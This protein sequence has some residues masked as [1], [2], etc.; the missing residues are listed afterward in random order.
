MYNKPGWAILR[1]LIEGG[2]Q[3]RITCSEPQKKKKLLGVDLFASVADVPPTDLAVLAIPANL[4]PE[5]V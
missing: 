1:N 5:A 2:F 3:R 4:C